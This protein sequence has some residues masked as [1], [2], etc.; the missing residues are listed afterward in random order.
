LKLKL[1]KQN[2]YERNK[3]ATTALERGLTTSLLST[4]SISSN[5]LQPIHGKALDI[6]K[7]F[8]KA[9]V[10]NNC[11]RNVHGAYHVRRSGIPWS[12][13][14]EDIA[15]LY[16][17]GKEDLVAKYRLMFDA[18]PHFGKEVSCLIQLLFHK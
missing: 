2:E 16:V 5:K 14:S 11:V 8:T 9:M 18:N 15:T 12:N 13:P 4:T 7:I 6:F 10:Y 1:K 3:N 17:E